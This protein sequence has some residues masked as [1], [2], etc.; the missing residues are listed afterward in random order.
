M[1]IEIDLDQH[2][3]YNDITT[4]SIQDQLKTKVIADSFSNKSKEDINRKRKKYLDYT[5]GQLIESI[6]NPISTEIALSKWKL[7]PRIA[8]TLI[9]DGITSFF[10]IQRL[11]I[12]IILND[13]FHSNHLYR[14]ICASAPTGSGKTLAYAIPIIQNLLNRRYIHLR[15]LIIL[16]TRELASQV[17]KVFCKIASKTDL[18]IGLASGHNLY[19]REKELLVDKNNKSKRSSFFS[20]E[21]LHDFSVHI[22]GSSKV[23]ILVCTPGRLLEHMEQ[24]EGFTLKHLRYLVLDEADRLLSNAYH[25]WIREL[26]RWKDNDFSDEYQLTDFESSSS[27]K[28]DIE[29]E[30]FKKKYFFKL[31]NFPPQRLLFSATLT[32]NPRKLNLLDIHN[33]LIIKI[34]DEISDDLDKD[35]TN[36][37]EEGT[38]TL[39]R[40]LTESICICD[41][42]TRPFLLVSILAQAC[43]VLEHENAQAE[44]IRCIESNSM[45]IIFSS[46]LDTA[47]RLYKL[48]DIMNSS[49]K[50]QDQ[51]SKKNYLF[52]GEVAEISNNVTEE[53]RKSII[54]KSIEGKIKI[55]VATDQMARGIDLSNINLVI[56][57]DPPKFARSYVHRAGRTA[58]AGKNGHC[59]TMLKF[60]QVSTFKGLRSEISS[61]N[62]LKKYKSL[63]N[64]V[65]SDLYPLY[66]SSLLKFSAD[67]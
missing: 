38:Y 54:N 32:D 4:I 37:L 31:S 62:K 55:L 39:P 11:V 12:P 18:K 29:L 26:T 49:S 8:Q 10:P 40:T 34:R 22:L 50:N 14:D 9:E 19:D 41:T 21:C 58:R 7:D 3:S 36:Y 56:N 44:H 2:S 52:G 33:P 46:S 59:L 24:T 47:G 17:H 48:L 25:N 42:E 51:T 67:D 61:Y 60:G 28:S 13:S 27:L 45:C 6:P 23:D 64:I 65:D 53:D 5:E 30:Y 63:R 57:Y 20:N 35:A 43:G 66:T 15:A 16:P 1:E